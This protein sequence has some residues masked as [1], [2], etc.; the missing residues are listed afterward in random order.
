MTPRA[1]AAARALAIDPSATP[2]ERVNA[3]RRCDEYEAIHGRPSTLHGLRAW[4][5]LKVSRKG[6]GRWLGNTYELRRAIRVLRDGGRQHCFVFEWSTVK[7][8][9]DGRVDWRSFPDAEPW[10]APAHMDGEG[11]YIGEDE[12]VVEWPIMAQTVK[13]E[14]APAPHKRS[15]PARIGKRR[16]R[17]KDQ[18][19]GCRTVKS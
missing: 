5:T 15:A 3:A 7:D 10:I 9:Q 14:R 16:R 8:V 18:L 12:R 6:T 1:Y 19:P 17:G 4:W 11:A 13:A 2:A